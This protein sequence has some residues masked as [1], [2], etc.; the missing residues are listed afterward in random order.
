MLSTVLVPPVALEKE[1]EQ[2]SEFGRGILIREAKNEFGI[3][4]TCNY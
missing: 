3:G 4:I 1:K 2:K